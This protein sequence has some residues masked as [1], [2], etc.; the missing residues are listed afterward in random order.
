MLSPAVFLD[1]D[2][3]IVNDVNHL[4]RV[5]Q[6]TLLPGVAR[7]IR[8]LNDLHIPVV[9]VTNQSVVARGIVSE[10]TL[11]AIH[12]ELL[13]MLRRE[14]AR[15]DGVYYCPHH[16]DLGEPPYR[17]ACT[18]RKPNPG[19]L[20]KAATEMSIALDLSFMIGDSLHDLEAGR[21]AGCAM[22]ILVLT[23][24]GS[25]EHAKL[26]AEDAKPDFV[27]QNLAEAVSHFRAMLTAERSQ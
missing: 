7:T 21:R 15:V 5:E 11:H 14:G 26:T 2:G 10:P 17:G 22:N 9:I 3:V 24:H 13:A 18:C 25:Q 4:S 1:R 16:P 20:L 27:A 19:L 6:L 8:E 23:G 12:E